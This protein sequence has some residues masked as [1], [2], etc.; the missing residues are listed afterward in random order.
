LSYPNVFQFDG[1]Y[2][3]IPETASTSRVELYRAVNFPW[4]WKFEKVLLSGSKFQ[5]VTWFQ[6]E[7]K[8]WLFAGGSSTGLGGQYDQLHLFHAP[9]VFDRVKPHP[10]NPVKTDLGSAR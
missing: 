1:K 4:E 2:Y 8:H 3:M 9:T 5:D 7:G 6:F 10:A